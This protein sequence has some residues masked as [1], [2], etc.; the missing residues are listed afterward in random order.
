MV[1][2]LALAAFLSRFISDTALGFSG[3][4]GLLLLAVE[5]DDEDEDDDILIV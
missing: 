2:V 3:L 1:F 5:D 4:G